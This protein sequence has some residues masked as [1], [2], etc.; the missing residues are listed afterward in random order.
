MEITIPSPRPPTMRMYAYAYVCPVTYSYA[1]PA[2]STSPIHTYIHV[3]YVYILYPTILPAKQ[4]KGNLPTY[5]LG[6]AGWSAVR[7][8]GRKEGQGRGNN[9]REA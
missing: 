3:Q 8:G 5:L 6:Q 4:E 7:S 9:G 2:I 1:A